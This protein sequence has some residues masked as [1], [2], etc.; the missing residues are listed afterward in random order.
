MNESVAFPE[1][2]PAVNFPPAREGA[3][4]KSADN[5]LSRM[6]RQL[7]DWLRRSAVGLGAVQLLLDA[8]RAGEAGEALATVR[9]DFQLLRHALDAVVEESPAP[10]HGTAARR[11]AT[12]R[13]SRRRF[14]GTR[15]PAG[16]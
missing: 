9:D 13:R 5:G 15:R 3:E 16:Q 1:S 11:P 7:R 8:G 10:R 2:N 6:D 4:D 14:P 12:D